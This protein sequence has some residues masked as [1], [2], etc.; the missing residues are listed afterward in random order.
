MFDSRVDPFHTGVWG[1]GAAATWSGRA[2]VEQRVNLGVGQ[3]PWWLAMGVGEAEQA[4]IA[5][6][7]RTVRL[8][9]LAAVHL[10]RVLTVEQLA[11]ITGE[12]SWAA[13]RSTHL[14]V[15]AAAGLID[16][17]R[18]AADGAQQFPTLIRPSRATPVEPLLARLRA[19]D[20]AGIIPARWL[21]SG[22]AD[23]HS[24]LATELCLRVAEAGLAPLVVGESACPITDMIPN[25]PASRRR[26]D[27]AWVRED[28]LVVAVELT[29]TLTNVAGKLKYWAS[30]LPH[31]PDMVVLYVV[32]ASQGRMAAQLRAEIGRAMRDLSA[33]QA[34]TPGRL[35]VVDW[36]DWFPAAH[37][38]SGA[39]ESLVV[40]R[41]GGPVWGQ[42]PLGQVPGPSVDRGVLSR[43]GTL[44][45]VPCWQRGRLGRVD[46]DRY[47][48]G[49]LQ[50]PGWP[51]NSGH[52]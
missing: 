10:W 30:V 33:V 14:G 6:R 27:G 34:G 42:A 2:Q 29:A 7:W 40:W 4:I 48:E 1:G 13:P 5:P 43:A 52:G 18:V 3:A 19:R 32:A 21:G 23:R 9:G 20:T 15:L 44:L 49:L 45:G 41:L 24:L 16:V 38:V 11:A 46:V 25:I 39:F 51:L 17:G 26:P 47:L 22:S 8:T 28:G 35:L 36:V 31:S 12:P 37:Q 50:V